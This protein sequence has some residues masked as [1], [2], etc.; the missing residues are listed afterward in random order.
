MRKLLRLKEYRLLSDCA[1]QVKRAATA[2]ELLPGREVVLP[3]E[4]GLV[5]RNG[6]GRRLARLMR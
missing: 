3:G 6:L 4:V 2:A 5:S 1:G